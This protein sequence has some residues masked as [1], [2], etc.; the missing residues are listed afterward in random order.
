VVVETE[1]VLGLLALLVVPAAEQLP[2]SMELLPLLQVAVRLQHPFKVIAVVIQVL[3]ALTC[4]MV[5]AGVRAQRV[6]TSP[7]LLP[8]LEM[9]AR[10]FLVQ[11]PVL[12]LLVVAV[13]VAE[14][15][16]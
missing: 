6:V 8:L 12:P 2:R 3:P 10:V 5:V 7:V 9:V 15:V 11:L 4:G 14:T 16:R 13:A 1:P